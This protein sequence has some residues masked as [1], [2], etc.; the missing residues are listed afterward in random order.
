MK[1]ILEQSNNY[2]YE[3]LRNTYG[4]APIQ[5]WAARAGISDEGI[6]SKLYTWYSARTLAK[7]W[8]VNYSWF[9]GGGAAQK[10]V[11]WLQNPNQ[12]VIRPVLGKKYT[13][14]SKGGWKAY[15]ERCFNDA[16]IVFAGNGPYVIAL[17]SDYPGMREQGLYGIVEALDACHNAIK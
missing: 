9:Q 8:L 15:P 1:G 12:S 13:L 7:L 11:S 10:V 17:M 3:L 5:T 14:Y 2:S 4:S 16:G 6:N